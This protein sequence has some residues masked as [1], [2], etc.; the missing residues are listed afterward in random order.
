MTTRVTRS[1]A[2]GVAA[3]AGEPVTQ[4]KTETLDQELPS[5]V[6]P[7]ERKGNGRKNISG[8]RKRD[9]SPTVKLE[10][11]DQEP[12]Q[13]VPPSPKR[14]RKD[15]DGHGM[16]GSSESN[17]G[18]SGV[19]QHATVQSPRRSRTQARVLGR[20]RSNAIVHTPPRILRTSHMRPIVD[21]LFRRR[22]AWFTVDLE[23]VAPGGTAK[24]GELPSF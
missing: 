3:Q 6:K 23:V 12:Y 5:E 4:I 19:A 17:E 16:V 9:D 7:K 2:K 20:K 1:R 22:E 10:S 8:K 15:S 24:S 13:S 21:E 14:R 18:R 11:G